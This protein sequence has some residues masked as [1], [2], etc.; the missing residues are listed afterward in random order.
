M[1]ASWEWRP[2]ECALC[3]CG[4]VTGVIPVTFTF[5]QSVSQLERSSAKTIKN[6]QASHPLLI[7][8]SSLQFRSS[9]KYRPFTLSLST[10]LAHIRVI[11]QLQ[12]GRWSTDKQSKEIFTT[13][14]KRENSRKQAFFNF[15]HQHIQTRRSQQ[16]GSMRGNSVVTTIACILKNMKLHTETPQLTGAHGTPY[17]YQCYTAINKQTTVLVVKFQLDLQH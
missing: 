9:E 12:L 1:H 17:S 15:L 6:I 4:R 5:M 13:A 14:H 2:C 11:S 8:S 10:M 16:A 7:V 3:A